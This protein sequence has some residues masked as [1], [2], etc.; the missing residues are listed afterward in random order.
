MMT[1]LHN[2]TRIGHQLNAIMPFLT[3]NRYANAKISRKENA[4]IVGDF[5]TTQ[6]W[7]FSQ[8]VADALQAN[9][10][11]FIQKNVDQGDT[12][13]NSFFTTHIPLDQDGLAEKVST[14][15]SS[16]Q[17]EIAA[18]ALERAKDAI[19]AETKFASLPPETQEA[20][21]RTV[22]NHYATITSERP[23]AEVSGVG[24]STNKVR[25]EQVNTRLP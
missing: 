24:A 19:E 22:A 12:P 17:A 3:G 23:T 15:V 1:E 9:K 10:I 13:Q 11:E 7:N 5:D 6:D 14:L 18:K 21:S 16:Y 8:Q 4:I 25:E 20:I 2:N